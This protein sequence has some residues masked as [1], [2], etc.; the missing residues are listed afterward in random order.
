MNTLSRAILAGSGMTL[1]IAYAVTAFR[2]TKHL[3]A[4]LLSL[5]VVIWM[6]VVVT[7]VAEALH[8]WPSMRW[9]EPTSP[10]HY[11]DLASA[12]LGL[13]LVAAGCVLAAVHR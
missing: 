7:H 12:I 9:G 10:G 11:L 6:I 5:G 2:R 1:L 13:V 4:G 8:L 3:S